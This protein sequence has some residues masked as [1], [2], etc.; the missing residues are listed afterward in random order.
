GEYDYS[1]ALTLRTGIGY[2]ISP[3]DAPSKRFTSIP[4]ND[5][6]YLSIGASYRYSEATTFDIGYSHLFV[7][8]GDFVRSPPGNPALV[9]SG[10]VESSVDLI[11]VGM[12]TRW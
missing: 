6:V 3:V 1:P 10:T 8:D 9:S 12:R 5:K 4:D 11:S 7:Q 2:E